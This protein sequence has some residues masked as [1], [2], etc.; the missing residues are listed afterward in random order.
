V[1]ACQPSPP[2]A[3]PGT[4]ITPSPTQTAVPTPAPPT[5]TPSLTPTATLTPTPT[6]A[7]VLRIGLPAEITTTNVWALFDQPGASFANYA[8]QAG[9]WPALFTDQHPGYSLIPELALDFPQ[10]LRQEGEYWVGEVQL[11]SGLEWSSGAPL[12]AYDAAFTANTAL[13]FDLGYYWQA[14]Y[15]ARYLAR[16]EPVDEH[17]LRYYLTHQPGITAWQYGVLQGPIVSQAYWQEKIAP[18]VE[19]MEAIQGFSHSSEPYLSRRQEAIAYLFNLDSQDE[20]AGGLFRFSEWKPG[21]YVEN[22]IFPGSIWHGAQIEVFASGAVSVTYRDGSSW[23]GYGPAQ[24]EPVWSYAYGPFFERVQYTVLPPQAAAAALRSGQIN[25][26]AAPP[27]AQPD[28]NRRVGNPGIQSAVQVEN[29]FRYLAFNQARPP[30]ADPLFRQA[31]A[32]LLD[33]EH[34]AGEM[35]PRQAVPVFSPVLPANLFWHNPQAEPL[36]AGMDARQ[37]MEQAVRMLAEG[38]YTWEVE[39][40]WTGGSRPR[41]EPG[42]GLRLPDGKPFPELLLLA[43]AAEVDALLSASAPEVMRLLGLL[44]VHLTLESRDADGMALEVYETGQYDLAL[45]HTRVNVFPSHLCLLFS[46]GNPFQYSNPLV[47]QACE[48]FLTTSELEQARQAV[49]DVQAVV[50][51]DAP[52]VFLFTSPVVEAWYGI[53]YP[54]GVVLE[55]YGAGLL[56]APGLAQPATGQP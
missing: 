12:T 23:Q 13:L 27:G 50:A 48:V 39:P 4:A 41:L 33:A 3:T 45:L 38:G 18:A 6:L 17:T 53:Q 52:F 11:K 54:P 25:A 7:P 8:V 37:R 30:L 16:V 2:A 36:C 31:A 20:P 10:P 55:G 40:D 51:V 5:P 15:D 21:A 49:L 1:S 9:Y 32:C 19:M 26:Y 29:G 35:L 14:A 24:G 22:V 46:T 44:G 34:L 47:D 42:V 56:G 28:V 43:P